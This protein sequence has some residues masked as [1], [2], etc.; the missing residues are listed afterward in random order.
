[1]KQEESEG[2]QAFRPPRAR[3][4]CD[5]VNLLVA[6]SERKTRQDLATDEGMICDSG[7]RGSVRDVEQP[8]D[9][10]KVLDRLR[11]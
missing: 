11:R 10:R 3:Y 8:G 6:Q 4:S 9:T 2:T 1:M 5:S 7:W